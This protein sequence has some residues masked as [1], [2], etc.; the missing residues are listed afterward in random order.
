MAAAITA[1]LQTAT[2]LCQHVIHVRDDA[3]VPAEGADDPLQRFTRDF[4]DLAD[5]LAR[6]DRSSLPRN[7]IFATEQLARACRKVCLDTF[8][9]LS[10]TIENGLAEDPPRFSYGLVWTEV[11]TE[12]FRAHLV[13]FSS[14]WKQIFPADR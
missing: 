8:L 12:A 13:D 5:R 1:F 9:R 7:T 3:V 6:R 10:R 2:L 11:D 4:E 14:Q